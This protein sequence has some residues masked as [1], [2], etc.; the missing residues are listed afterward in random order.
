MSLRSN[1]ELV[2][3][4]PPAGKN[5]GMKAEDIVRIHGHATTTEKIVD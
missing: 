3:R 5:M 4:Q 2:V 1:A